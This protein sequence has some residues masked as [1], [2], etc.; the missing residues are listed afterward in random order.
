MT[1]C[2]ACAYFTYDEDDEV[3][4]WFCTMDLDEDEMVRFLSSSFD[5]CPYY[6]PGDEYRIVRRQM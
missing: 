4:A 2:E 3:D 5:A 6:Q 1:N